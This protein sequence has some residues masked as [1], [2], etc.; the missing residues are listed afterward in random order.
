M[1]S[2][3]VNNVEIIRIIDQIMFQGFL[4]FK[5]YGK[6]P[7]GEKAT[8]FF[9]GSPWTNPSLKNYFDRNMG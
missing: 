3:T 7:L 6:L 1:I 4:N 5:V 8:L 2:A 9:V